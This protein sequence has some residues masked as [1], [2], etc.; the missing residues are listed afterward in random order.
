MAD[1][2][3][4]F[5]HKA[6][7]IDLLPGQF[8]TSEDLQALVTALVGETHGVQE[9]EAVFW[10]LYSLRWLWIA[11]G[12]Q[13]EGIGDILNEPRVSDDDEEYRDQL[14]LKILINVSEGE[15]ER[16]IQAVLQV[17]G[18]SHVH[19][20]DKHYATVVLWAYE[21]TKTQ[22]IYRVPQVSLGGVMTVVTGSTSSTP[23]VFGVDRNEDGF[24]YGSELPY[25]EGWG[26]IG[27]GNEGYGGNFSE[28]Y[29]Q[30]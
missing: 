30:E 16:L 15:P 27:A 17:A 5:S 29:W 8:E 2:G 9:L 18:G 14:Y 1:I 6:V 3:K 28:L 19:L 11:T 25:G 12:A 22:F 4:Q 26:E 10:E 21:L 7:A 24:G 13:L 20:I 23:F